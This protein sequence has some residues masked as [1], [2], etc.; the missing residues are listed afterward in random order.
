MPAQNANLGYFGIVTELR[1]YR[2]HRRRKE[3]RHLIT[4]SHLHVAHYTNTGE[5]R[6]G[7]V[8][9]SVLTEGFLQ[10]DLGFPPFLP[11]THTGSKIETKNER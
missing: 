4:K 8:G 2:L 6:L 5:V 11:P 9:I 1:R 10:L 3:F 7:R